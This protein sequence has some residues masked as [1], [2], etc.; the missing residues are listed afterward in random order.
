MEK[1][2]RI[3]QLK[4]MLEKHPQDVFLKYALGLEYVALCDD[5][6]GRLTFEQVI[7]LQE[8]YLAV[9]FQL[10][11]LYE[12]IGEDELAIETYEKGMEVAKNQKDQK[13]LNELKSALEELMF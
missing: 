9:Y 8:D 4:E 6:N 2:A 11:Q 3:N 10:A 7:V 5:E 1:L 13:T 12:R